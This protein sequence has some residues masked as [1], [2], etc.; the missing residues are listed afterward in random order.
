MKYI[1][2]K[3]GKDACFLQLLIR[4]LKFLTYIF[5]AT[6]TKL[7]AITSTMYKEKTASKRCEII[8]YN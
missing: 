8:F 6:R 1:L 4:F 7:V 5:I 3:K 2:Q